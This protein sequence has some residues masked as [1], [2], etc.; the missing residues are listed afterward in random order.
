MSLGRAGLRSLEAEQDNLGQPGVSSSGA[1][2]PLR[3]GLTGGIGSGKSTVAAELAQLGA[4]VVDTDAIARR[5]TSAGGAAMP[6]LR[7][8]FGDAIVTAD[9]ALDRDAMR[10]LAFSDPDARGRLEAVLHPLIGAQAQR[11]AAAATTTDVI[12]FDVPLLV[13]AGHWRDRV[14]R[15]LVVD[16]SPATQIDRVAQRTGWTANAARSVIASQASREQRRAVADAVVFNDGID[17]RALAALVQTLWGFWQA[18][19]RKPVEQ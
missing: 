19:I 10:Q 12:V 18:L 14:D 2:R 16:C 8:T 5:L 7:R 6:A 17:R 1:V 4:T 9:G 13:E 11:E 15:V 3:I